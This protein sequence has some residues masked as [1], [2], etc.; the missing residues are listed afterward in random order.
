LRL[1]E[2]VAFVDVDVARV[3]AL[4][5]A[6]RN[7]LQRRAVE[8][9]YLDVAREG[10]EP[11]EPTLALNAVQ[12]RVPLHGLAHV[13]HV[14]HDERVDALPELALPSR[15]RGDVRL[16]RGVAVS[17]RDAWVAT[18]EDGLLAFAPLDRLGVTPI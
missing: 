2:L 1:V 10:V 18:R 5:G 7:G 3:L 12:R 13:G 4:A 15:H 17:L 6:G 11:E 16:H 8:E 14:A 9:G